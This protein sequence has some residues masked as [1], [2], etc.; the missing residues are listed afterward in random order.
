MKN[1]KKKPQKDKNQP[2]SKEQPP[3][4]TQQEQSDYS[5]MVAI[6]TMKKLL[7]EK[8]A[9]KQTPPTITPCIGFRERKRVDP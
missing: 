8:K 7:K 9:N 1:I 5:D 3:M 6:R 2:S 4:S